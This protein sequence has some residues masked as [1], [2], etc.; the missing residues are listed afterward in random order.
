MRECRRKCKLHMVMI[1][2]ECVLRFKL[3]TARKKYSHA[4]I[5]NCGEK[6]VY[7]LFLCQFACV[8]SYFS[9]CLLHRYL[10]QTHFFLSGYRKKMSVNPMLVFL[11]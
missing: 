6:D 7:F 8:H 2:F 10:F 4:C 1:R 9:C 11:F 5:H 3:L